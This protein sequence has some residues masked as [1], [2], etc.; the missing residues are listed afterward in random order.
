VKNSS[1][2]EEYKSLI[3]GRDTEDDDDGNGEEIKLYDNSRIKDSTKINNLSLSIPPEETSYGNSKKLSIIFN[4]L[5]I[6]I[7]FSK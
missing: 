3:K 6:V 5:F 4:L 7:F 1:I 2:K